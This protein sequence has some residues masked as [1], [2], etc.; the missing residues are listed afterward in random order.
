[1]GWG[2]LTSNVD[3]NKQNKKEKTEWEKEFDELIG[4]L[5]LNN[6]KKILW[7]NHKL[8]F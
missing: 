7:L 3:L 8:L 6:M 2:N 5:F 4:Q 1:M